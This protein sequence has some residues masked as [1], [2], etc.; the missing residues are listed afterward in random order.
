MRRKLNVLV[1]LV[2]VLA[3][4]AVIQAHATEDRWRVLRSLPFPENYPAP[5]SAQ[6]LIDEM[7]FQRVW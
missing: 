6:R 1:A 7:L 3:T 2:A 4:Q 5:E